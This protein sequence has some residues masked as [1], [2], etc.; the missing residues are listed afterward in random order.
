MTEMPVRARRRLEDVAVNWHERSSRYDEI[1]EQQTS[2]RRRRMTC[3]AS[4]PAYTQSQDWTGSLGLRSG[5]TLETLKEQKEKKKILSREGIR[6]DIAWVTIGL[7]IALMLVILVGDLSGI[8]KSMRNISKLSTRIGIVTEKN[9]R[10]DAELSM[11]TDDL[12]V[13]M[14][15]V[16]LNLIGSGGART[17][18]LT[19]PASATMKVTAAATQNGN[20]TNQGD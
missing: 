2:L 1:R 10:L 13:C 3:S 7:V 9:E 14:E 5:A 6:W 16:K 8:G 11:S 17:V 15:A 12:S 4:L 18:R 20:Q 19:A